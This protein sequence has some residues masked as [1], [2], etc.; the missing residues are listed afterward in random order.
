MDAR[1]F[2]TSVAESN[3]NLGRV[4]VATP[5][6]PEWLTWQKGPVVA[7]LPEGLGVTDYRDPVIRRDP[8][9]WR[10]FVGASLYSDTAVVFSYTSQDLDAWEYEGIVAQRSAAETEPIWTGTLWEC[11]QI[12]T[13]GERAAMVTS[14]KPRSLAAVIPSTRTRI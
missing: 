3:L 5:G 12:F 2:Y 7:A 4:R 13:S 9:A 6:D 11:P 10:M 14:V 1:I 8:D